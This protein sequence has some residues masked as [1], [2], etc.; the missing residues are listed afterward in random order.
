MPLVR[1]RRVS[2]ALEHMSQVASAVAA[3]NLRPLHAESAVCVPCDGARDCVEESR[4]AAAGLELVLGRVDGRVAAG[5]VIGAGAR[6]VLIVLAG[7]GR[8]GALLAE[9]AELLW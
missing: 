7:E 1:R 9:D 3:N 6:G 5:T 4:P 2:L 8:F